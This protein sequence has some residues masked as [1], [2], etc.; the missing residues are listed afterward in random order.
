MVNR[1]VT[2][3]LKATRWSIKEI[4]SKFVVDCYLVGCWV[5]KLPDSKSLLFVPS[6]SH[7]WS[8]DFRFLS[9]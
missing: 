6:F 4:L 5:E 8:H 7:D 2:S 3:Y 9:V 1:G